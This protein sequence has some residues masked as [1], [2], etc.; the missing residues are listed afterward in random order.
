MMKNPPHFFKEGFLKNTGLNKY[1]A[2]RKLKK[3][4]YIKWSG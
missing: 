4:I 1:L 2:D 3:L